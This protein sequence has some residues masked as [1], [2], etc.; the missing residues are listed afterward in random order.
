MLRKKIT[1]D[2][3]NVP[4]YTNSWTKVSLKTSAQQNT[5][6]FGDFHYFQNTSYISVVGLPPTQA[7]NN[8]V[9]TW[10]KDIHGADQIQ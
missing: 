1:Y 7:G 10:K 9:N 4:I 5:C 8:N 6:M 3:Y 2:L